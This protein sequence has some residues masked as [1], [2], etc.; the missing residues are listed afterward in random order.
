MAYANDIEKPIITVMY[1]FFISGIT[2][3]PKTDTRK[4]KEYIMLW[5][6]ESLNSGIINNEIS[7]NLDLINRN[8]DSKN[9]IN[10]IAII[11]PEYLFNIFIIFFIYSFFI[12]HF[13]CPWL[14]M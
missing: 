3:I 2:D 11:I 10:R 12:I 4:T 14:D 6:G 5:A 13:M 8:I 7:I 9:R 1:L